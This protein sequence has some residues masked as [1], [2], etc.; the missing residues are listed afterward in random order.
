MSWYDQDN[1][2]KKVIDKSYV[3]CDE[4]YE[5]DALVGKVV[6]ELGIGRDLAKKAVNACCDKVSAPRSRDAFWEC[7]KDELGL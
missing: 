5:V 6:K 2:K 3:S 7:L 4:H 1:K